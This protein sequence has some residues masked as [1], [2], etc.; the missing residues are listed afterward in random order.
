MHQQEVGG[1]RLLAF[2]IGYTSGHRYSGNTCGTDQRVNRPMRQ[3]AH[4]IAAQQAAGSGNAKC[5]NTQQHDL[6]CACRQEGRADHGSTDGGRQ[7]HRNNVHQCIL[8]GIAQTIGQAGFLE[9]VAQHQAANQ[10]SGIR[11]QQ[12]DK[13]GNQDGE[14]DLLGLGHGTGL[15]HLDLSLRGS[16]QQ[17]HDGRL[18]QR[19]QCHVAVC[20][21]GN[22]TQQMR[23]KARGQENGS[24]AVSAAD[25]AD[26][27]SLGAGKAQCHSAHKGHKYAQLCSSAQ[28]Q[29]L[30]IGKQRAKICHGANA[31]E[32]QAGINACLYTDIEN[33]DQTAFTHNLAEAVI[34]GVVRIHKGIPQF[35]MVKA[36]I[37][38]IRQNTAKGNANQQQRLK[39]LD[40]GKVHQHA[41]DYQHDKVL[42]AVIRHEA[43]ENRIEA[44]ARPQIQK[45]STN[46]HWIS[47]LNRSPSGVRRYPQ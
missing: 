19:D 18:N 41:A 5:N 28:Q 34:C 23:R 16:G 12:C 43:G 36:C 31:H 29:A 9:E 27:C 32:D 6:Q 40:N 45:D 17:I 10:R 11:Q 13:D 42:P 38:Q 39:L 3:H 35:L 1:I 26:G 8:G 22:G 47:L 2:L 14:D 21:H 30:G 4:Y 15:H 37:R 46:I 44:G 7:K 24:G 25:D 20:R 33:I